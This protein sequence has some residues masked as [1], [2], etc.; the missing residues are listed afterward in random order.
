[1]LGAIRLT[2]QRVNKDADAAAGSAQVLDLVRRD[3][4]IDSASADAHHLARL[5]NADCLPFHWGIPPKGC[6]GACQREIR[7]AALTLS[8]SVSIC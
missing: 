4:V 2:P 8:D 6:I 5:H 7:R 1:M 3:P